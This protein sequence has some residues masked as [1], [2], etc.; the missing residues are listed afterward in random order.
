[1][2]SNSTLDQLFSQDWQ[3]VAYETWQNAKAALSLTHKQFSEE[4]R[5]TFFP[6]DKN[7][8]R[9]NTPEILANLKNKYAEIIEEDWQ[10]AQ[11]GIYPQSL[12]FETNWQEF[13]QAYLSMWLDYPNS[14]SRVQQKQYQDFSSNINLDQYPQYYRRN[15]HY[16]TDG[17][18]SDHSANLYDLQVDILFNGLAD[19]MRRRIL[20]PLVQELAKLENDDSLKVLDVACGTGRT[21]KFLREALPSASLYGID[22]S[23]AYLRKANQWLSQLPAELP[24]LIQGNA[25]N[26][27]YQDNYFQGISNVFLF[28]E[29]PNPVRQRVIDECFRVLQPGGIFVICDSIQLSD[30]KQLA[31][32]LGNFPAMFHEPYYM[33]YV[34]D[35]LDKKLAE[36]GF[37]NIRTKTY[38]FSKYWL[39][40]K[41]K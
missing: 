41:A 17:Y 25:E 7:L 21:L 19:C 1:M 40:T 30:D 13:C 11:A 34:K 6:D 27:P 28:H 16:Q 36:A 32:M 20:K 8:F 37:T 33:D 10:D 4:L 18:L 2:Q 15:F 3:K 29:L 35:N 24:Q 9:A 5:K 22:L 12:L 23:P 39:A 31:P 26:L 38:A 14:W